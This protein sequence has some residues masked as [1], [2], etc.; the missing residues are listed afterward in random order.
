LQSAKFVNTLV[1]EKK[2]L[3]DYANLKHKL[4]FFQ[5]NFLHTHT[6]THTHTHKHTQHTHQHTHTHVVLTN[7]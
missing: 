5:N 7:L 1:G 2:Y 6:H 3:I 4:F